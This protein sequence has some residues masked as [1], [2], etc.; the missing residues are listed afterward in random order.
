M[1]IAIF[2]SETGV[3]LSLESCSAM[4]ATRSG[5]PGIGTVIVVPVSAFSD[6]PRGMEIICPSNSG[7]TISDEISVVDRPWISF[8]HVSYERNMV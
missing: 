6:E 5:L 7:Q 8:S 4:S 3:L 2:R 1:R